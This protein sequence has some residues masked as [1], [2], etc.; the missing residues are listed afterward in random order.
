MDRSM[1]SVRLVPGRLL[2]E[3]QLSPSQTVLDHDLE[4]GALQGLLPLGNMDV[5]P[6]F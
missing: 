3:N 6:L 4:G 5:V 2:D 1:H